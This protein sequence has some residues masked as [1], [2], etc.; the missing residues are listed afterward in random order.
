MESYSTGSEEIQP[1]STMQFKALRLEM[2]EGKQ[3]WKAEQ[4]IME[5]HLKNSNKGN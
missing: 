1:V 5:Q 2:N 4:I 3:N